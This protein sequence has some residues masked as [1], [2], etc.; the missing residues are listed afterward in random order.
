[1]RITITS[2]FHFGYSLN[3]EIGEDSF[4]NAKEVLLK[5]GDSD[6]ILIAGDLFDS[7]IPTTEVWKKAFETL[8]IPILTEN[9]NVKIV[10]TIGKGIKKISQITLNRTPIIAIHGTHERMGRDQGN[11][12]QALEE[13]GFLIHLHCNGVV[14]EKNGIKVAIQGM[15]GVPERYAKDILDKWNPKPIEDCY[16]ILLIHQ[17]IEP[18]IYSPLDPPSLSLNNLPEGFDLIING[19]IHSPH[20][21]SIGETDLLM[22][23]STIITQLKDEELKNPKGF[24]K[25]KL[26]EKKFDFIQIEK[27]RKIFLI[28]FDADKEYIGKIKKDL[29]EILKE[30]LDKKPIIKIK[31]QGKKINLIDKDISDIIKKY[32]KFC[33]FSIQKKFEEGK[34]DKKIEILGKIRE[35][36]LSIEEMGMK[37]LMDNLS[38]M[39]FNGEFNPE[40]LFS[41]LSEDK[42]DIAFNIL[43]NKQKTLG[44]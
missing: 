44:G 9:K 17:S 1:M 5:S 2:D 22:P 19:H 16:N 18:Y 24:Y 15:S 31:I 38:E 4:E 34:L 33:I 28:E 8:S 3:T 13:T 11:A 30:K 20:K 21:T 26:P 23:G 10:N 6:I 25:L 14:L 43:L 7:R 29:D 12:I 35:E 40:Y 36:K 41:I 37:I 27:S 32:G 39:K 42:I